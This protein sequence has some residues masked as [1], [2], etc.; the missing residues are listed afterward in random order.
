MIEQEG[1]R[2]Q[3][4]CS[5]RRS[6]Q[7]VSLQFVA[8]FVGV[9]FL[10]GLWVGRKWPKQNKE[11]AALSKSYAD[12]RSTFEGDALTMTLTRMH[13]LSSVSSNLMLGK[14]GAY[15]PLSEAIAWAR[16]NESCSLA[17]EPLD[18]DGW[19]TSWRTRSSE[20]EF[21]IASAGPDRRHQTSDDLGEPWD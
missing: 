4:E 18:K 15:P 8:I 12:G 11:P 1:H 13:Y 16:E 21:R 5:K 20:N 17:L 3:I 7:N 19:G 9:A 6:R 2:S 14:K 10:G